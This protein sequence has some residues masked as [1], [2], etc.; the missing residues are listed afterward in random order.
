NY[1]TYT[2]IGNFQPRLGIS[3]RPD[4]DQKSVFRAAYDI[5]SY[6]EGNGVNNMAVVNPPNVI[7]TDVKN[8]N[9][10]DLPATT[11]DQ[12]YSTFSSACTAAQL[13]AFA[14]NCISGVQVHATNKNL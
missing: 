11:F 7:M 5:S 8:L 13:E 6:M 1:N 3:W 12:G 2:G 10:T 4:W 14:A 9:S